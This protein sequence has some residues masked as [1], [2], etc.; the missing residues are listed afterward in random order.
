MTGCAV[1]ICGKCSVTSG[2]RA[3]VDGPAFTAAGFTPAEYTRDKTGKKLAASQ[4]RHGELV[5]RK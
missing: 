5:Q 1:G 2:E 3:C 4:L